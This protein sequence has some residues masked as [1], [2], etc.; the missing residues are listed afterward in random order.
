MCF[1]VH[2][3][4]AKDQD[5]KY[6]G[7]EPRCQWT[8]LTQYVHLIVSGGLSTWEECDEEHGSILDLS[9]CKIL[10][11][12]CHTNVLKKSFRDDMWNWLLRSLQSVWLWHLNLRK[13]ES[14][15]ENWQ[16]LSS[17]LHSLLEATIPELYQSWKGYAV[18]HLD[19]VG[20]CLSRI[21]NKVDLV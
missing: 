9:Q 13:W 17:Q 8:A 16:H 20:L 7:R 4:Q 10:L 6:L 1:L 5:F 11:T 21:L 14:K 15:C 19:I 12:A 2:Y 3:L 18:A